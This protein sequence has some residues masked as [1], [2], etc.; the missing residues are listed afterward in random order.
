MICKGETNI[1]KSTTEIFVF[2]WRKY[3][4]VLYCR[5]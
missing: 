4:S 1:N 5:K 3:N 2:M